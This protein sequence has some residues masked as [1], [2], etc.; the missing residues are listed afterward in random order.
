MWTLC[1]AAT[2]LRMLL[3]MTLLL[4]TTTPCLTVLVVW[5]LASIR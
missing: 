3:L 2:A 4:V 1:T 5:L